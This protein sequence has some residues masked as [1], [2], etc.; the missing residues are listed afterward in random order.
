[1]NPDTLKKLV[2]TLFELLADHYR[3]RPVIRAAIEAL[4]TFALANL[5]RLLDLLRLRG[6]FPAVVVVLGLVGPAAAGEA[7]ARAK[8]A[9]ALA[10]AG[11]RPAAGVCDCGCA[12]GGACDCPDC[13]RRAGPSEAEQYERAVREG[14]PLVYFVGQPAQAVDGCLSCCRDSFPGVAGPAVV[15]GVPHAGTLWRTATL[16][17]A[18]SEAAI[19]AAVWPGAGVAVCGGCGCCRR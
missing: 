2:E 19:R 6:V 9:L 16:P 13:P 15:V 17:G 3:D 10:V 12:T 18:P 7:D 11:L 4:E 5:E 8:A 1:M 14:R